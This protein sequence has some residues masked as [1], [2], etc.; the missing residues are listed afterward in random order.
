MAGRVEDGC[1]SRLAPGGAR[2]GGAEP[3]LGIKAKQG[4]DKVERVAGGACRREGHRARSRGERAASALGPPRARR[5]R[6]RG[7]AGVMGGGGGLRRRPPRR[8]CGPE[9][10]GWTR[11]RRALGKEAAPRVRVERGQVLG[12]VVDVHR[13]QVLGGGGAEHLRGA[14]GEVSGGQ[15]HATGVGAGP[16]TLSTSSSCWYVDASLAKSGHPSISSDTMHPKDHLQDRVERGRSS[17]WARAEA[18]S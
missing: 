9:A 7:G 16:R 8:R 1:W 12:R 15:W 11:R 5:K 13:E 10:A 14:G 2:L 4:S 3:P 17:S 18:G 6:R